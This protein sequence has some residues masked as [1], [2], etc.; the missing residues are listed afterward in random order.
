[1]PNGPK[2]LAHTMIA[3]HGVD[4]IRFA[5]EA[6][7]YVR[8]AGVEDRMAEWEAVIAAIKAIQK[9]EHQDATVAANQIPPLPS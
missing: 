8:A 7:L 5:E 3:I 2:P 9:A 6:L 1:M 4:A